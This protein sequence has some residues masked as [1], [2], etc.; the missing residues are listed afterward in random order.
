[1]IYQFLHRTFISALILISALLQPAYASIEIV[2][3]VN[4]HPITNYDLSQRVNFLA[5]VTKIK[6]NDGNRQRIEADALQ[7]LIDEKLK[8]A[9]AQEIDA[10]IAE[11]SLAMARK[12]VDSSFQQNGKNGF[13]VLR[14]LQLDTASIE[15]KFV[16][17]LAWASF[18]QAKFGNRLGDVDAKIDAELA[19]I[20]ESATKPQIQISEL[21]LLPEPNR[22]LQETLRL[23]NQIIVAVD[24]GAN[25]NA[26]AQQY[27]VAGSAQNGGRIGWLSTNRLPQN[28]TNALAEID[29]GSVTRPLQVDGA[30]LLFQK[31]GERKNGQADPSQDR[32]WLTRALLPLPAGAANADRLEAAARLERDTADISN[33]PDLLKLHDSYG[34]NVQGPLDN[35]IIG[36]LSPQMLNLVKE[37]KPGITS[38]PLSFGE[39]VAV[40]ML[41]KREKA[42][43]DLPS[44][45]DVER[46]IVEKLFGS[47]GERYLLRLRRAA[48]IERR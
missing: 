28:V 17:D 42:K 31:N 29:V 35:I 12:L 37:L 20:F 25:F 11:R 47:L 4:G 26:I 27:S 41:C 46:V 1:V 33:C 24:Q 18:V 5:A 21:V 16:T 7:M 39:G 44:R 15:Q 36:N 40:F 8:L 14:E 22:P 38:A 32:I 9:A 48:A 30:I 13:E 19:R 2:A 10:N 6:L 3:K 23:A 45:K 34:S 43:I